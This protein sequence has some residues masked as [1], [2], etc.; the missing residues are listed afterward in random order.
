MLRLDYTHILITT[1]LVG[2]IN[3]VKDFLVGGKKY[4]IRF[5]EDLEFGLGDDTCLVAYEEENES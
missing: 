3:E 5:V 1:K 2:G 4:P